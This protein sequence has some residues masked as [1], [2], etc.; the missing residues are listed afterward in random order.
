MG[1]EQIKAEENR[2]EISVLEELSLE[3]LLNIQVEI[4]SRQ[5]N[6]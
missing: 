5:M 6:I 1:E 4:S 3:C 2:L